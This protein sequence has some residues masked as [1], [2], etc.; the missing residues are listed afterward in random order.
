LLR[1]GKFVVTAEVSPPDGA[2][3]KEVLTAAGRLGQVADALNVTDGAGASCHMSSLG[4]CALLIQAGWVVVYQVTCRD[5]NRIA[6]QGD[7]L[8]A[9]AVGIRN[10]LCL[11]GD[12]VTIGDQP[13]AKRVF[14]LDSIQLLQTAKIMRDE[15]IY[16]SGRR[17]SEPPRF[18]LGAADNPFVEPFEFRPLRLAKKVQAGAEF[19]QTQFCFDIERLRSHMEKVRDLGVHE[20]CFILVGVGPL[21]SEGTAAFLRE[22]VPGVFIP[23][24]I[25]ERMRHTPSQSKRAEGRQICVE[26]IQ[27]VMEIEG[28][29]G[30]HMMAHGQEETAEEIIE[31]VGLLPRPDRDPIVD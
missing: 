10:V 1:A 13:Q 16:L 22:R 24:A 26:I 7:L 25:V 6:I 20:K 19:I 28:V 23:D 21:R 9:S 18:L 27:Q 15:G 2:N 11:T 31:E 30:I 5:R 29:S 17:L 3:P 12:D 4:A 14:D 8:G